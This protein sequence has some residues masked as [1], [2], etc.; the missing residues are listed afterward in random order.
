ME[1]KF[2]RTKDVIPR[3]RLPLL[4]RVIHCVKCPA[5]A[6]P[7]GMCGSTRTAILNGECDPQSGCIILHNG[8]D[9]AKMHFLK[10]VVWSIYA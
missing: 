6:F 7:P 1:E 3:A 2:N 4:I 8:Y 10:L 5:V 9:L